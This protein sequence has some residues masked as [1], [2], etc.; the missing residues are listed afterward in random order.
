MTKS[1]AKTIVLMSTVSVFVVACGG[2][3]G[4]GDSGPTRTVACAVG[5]PATPSAPANITPANAKK[6]ASLALSAVDIT[7]LGNKEFP[8][9]VAVTSGGE[10]FGLLRL[11][12]EDV[13]D[14][15]A[16]VDSAPV[17]LVRDRAPAVCDDRNPATSGT[18]SGSEEDSD[19]DFNTIAVGD[20]RKVISTNCILPGSSVSLNGESCGRLT[21]VTSSTLKPPYTLGKQISHSNM[22]ATSL[23]TQAQS[24]INGTFDF[25]ANTNDDKNFDGTVKVSSSAA[26]TQAR[27]GITTTVYSLDAGFSF[28]K[29]SNG[30]AIKAGTTAQVGSNDPDIAGSV[31]LRVTQNFTGNAGVN[32][33][34]PNAGT[35][36][37]EGANGTNLTLTGL[38]DG[39]NA[40]IDVGSDGSV[41][42]PSVPWNEL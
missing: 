30:Y 39:V 34:K 15:N 29:D 22:V 7:S 26:F 40:S 27:S 1:C 8:T 32:R 4:G 21:T 36:V 35:V 41:D 24:T 6:V 12:I 37:V 3:G 28:A 18:R 17:G 33:G 42:I 38:A 31:T 19:G 11:F 23:A 2:G 16:R 10:S 5:S 9:G 14:W 25:L 20:T 13:K